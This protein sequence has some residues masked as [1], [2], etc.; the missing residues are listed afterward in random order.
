MRF[1]IAGGSGMIG[2]A[3]TQRLL[4]DGHSVT[5]LSRDPAAHSVPKGASLVPWDGKTPDG[6]G[7]LIND[8]DAVVNLSGANIG[9]AL[10]TKKRRE[11]LISSRLNSGKALVEA[12][13]A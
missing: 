1:L 2:T 8:T 7:H 10:W 11:Q 13:Q 9:G 6:W 5:I 4:A 3:L 12:F